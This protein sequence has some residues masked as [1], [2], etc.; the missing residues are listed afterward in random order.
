MSNKRYDSGKI[1]ERGS[2]SAKPPKSG[3]R[4]TIT[5]ARSGEVT[6]FGRSLRGTELKAL[7]KAGRRAVLP[8]IKPGEEGKG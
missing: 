2:A 4:A 6:Q 7:E 3:R 1:A 5:L 8:Q